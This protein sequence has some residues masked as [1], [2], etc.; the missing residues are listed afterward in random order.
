MPDNDTAL[1]RVQT[2]SDPPPKRSRGGRPRGSGLAD[3][4]K[5]LPLISELRQRPGKWALLDHGTR[6]ITSVYSELVTFNGCEFTTR[7]TAEGSRLYGRYVGDQE[8][9]S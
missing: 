1:V 9:A 7:K 2:W 5:H 4:S 8:V 3:T 6:S